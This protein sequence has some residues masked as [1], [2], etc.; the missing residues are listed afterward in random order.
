ML[1]LALVIVY[2]SYYIIN[3][4]LY[5]EHVM[6]WLPVVN[7]VLQIVLLPLATWFYFYP[8]T[9]WTKP[10]LF[11]REEGPGLLYTWAMG[12]IF[13]MGSYV[14][15]PLTVFGHFYNYTMLEEYESFT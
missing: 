7:P 9:E 8:D 14:V 2:S 11:P 5:F 3:W 1:Y 4:F 12:K 6:F 15:L 13:F 10:E